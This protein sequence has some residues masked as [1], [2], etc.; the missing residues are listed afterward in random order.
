MSHRRWLTLLDRLRPGKGVDSIFYSYINMCLSKD[1][2]LGQKIICN[3]NVE[4][5]DVN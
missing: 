3:D 4:G 2:M 1:K 5:N